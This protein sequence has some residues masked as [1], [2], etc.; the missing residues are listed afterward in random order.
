LIVRNYFRTRR[1]NASEV[2]G[3]TWDRL[4]GSVAPRVHL[5]GGG[6]ILLAAIWSYGY[7]KLELAATAERILSLLGVQLPVQEEFPGRSLDRA[8]TP[9]SPSGLPDWSPAGLPSEPIGTVEDK[10]AFPAAAK[11][12]ASEP[13]SI[14]TDKAAFLAWAKSPAGLPG[15]PAGVRRPPRQNRKGW[16]IA[17]SF[18]PGVLL[19][20]WLVLA[21]RNAS[22]AWA[23]V[24]LALFIVSACI[25]FAVGLVR[26]IVQMQRNRSRRYPPRSPSGQG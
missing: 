1:A 14:V 11:S 8:P 24:S 18:V 2:R 3:I 22:S 15:E 23:M 26:T 17:L 25:L 20:T 6:S 5:A 19:G 12:P 4:R 7:G 21:Q 10:A 13:I 16:R 9:E